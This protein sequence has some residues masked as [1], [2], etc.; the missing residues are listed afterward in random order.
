ML[1]EYLTV[2][3]VYRFIRHLIQKLLRKL[4]PGWHAREKAFRGWYIQLVKRFQYQDQASYQAYVQAFEVPEEVRGY[5]EVR[6]PKM[7]LAMSKAEAILKN[8]QPPEKRSED[9][10]HP[11]RN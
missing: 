4:L 1:N 5:R 11:V 6:Y 3:Y 9:S 7:E 2:S 10:V 8:H